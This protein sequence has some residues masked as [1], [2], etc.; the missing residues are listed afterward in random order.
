MTIIVSPAGISQHWFTLNDDE[1]RLKVIYPHFKKAYLHTN[2]VYI[3]L[4]QFKD[5]VDS[6]EL[7]PLQQ[8]EKI[9]L[10]NIVKLTKIPNISIHYANYYNDYS[11]NISTRPVTIN[12]E[13]LFESKDIDH[14]NYTHLRAYINYKDLDHTRLKESSLFVVNGLVHYSQYYKDY[15][16]INNAQD[17]INYGKNKSVGVITFPIEAKLN[18]VKF[19]SETVNTNNTINYIKQSTDYMICIAGYLFHRLIGG[20]STDAN[21]IH[22]N[23]S[24]MNFNKKLYELSKYIDPTKLT[25][26]LSS[27]TDTTVITQSMLKEL[28]MLHNSFII[29]SDSHLTFD[30]QVLEKINDNT[31]T[32]HTTYEFNPIVS[33]SIGTI[34]NYE[35]SNTPATTFHLESNTSINKIYKSSTNKLLPTNPLEYMGAKLIGIRVEK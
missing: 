4:L 32:T 27:I 3:D 8:V 13:S 33:A 28:L 2:G 6:Y 26:N 7:L 29:T 18:I 30:T 9:G 22:L 20:I 25:F 15:I 14:Y 10:S 11:F 21:A 23:Y 34:H 31:Y 16:L 17:T 5:D 24:N 1:F 19:T 12:D 35:L